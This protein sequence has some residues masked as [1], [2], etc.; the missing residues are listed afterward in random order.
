MSWSSLAYIH[1]SHWINPLMRSVGHNWPTFI[2]QVISCWHSFSLFSVLKSAHFMIGYSKY[3]LVFWF[4]Q[5]IHFIFS[6][7]IL[8]CT[9]AVFWSIRYL[10]HIW[11]SVPGHRFRNDGWYTGSSHLNTAQARTVRVGGLYTRLP[12][13]QQMAEILT[14]Y[15]KS[16]CYYYPRWAN[17]L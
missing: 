4:T 3:P 10:W 2:S 12:W 17:F 13:Y 5:I 1:I 6:P 9:V 11:W 16:I 15:G 7:H 14:K 8:W